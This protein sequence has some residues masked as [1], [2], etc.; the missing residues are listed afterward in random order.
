M[1]MEQQTAAAQQK[2]MGSKVHKIAA[3]LRGLLVHMGGQDP[4]ADAD[5]DADAEDNSKEDD[6]SSDVG[7]F[8][9]AAHVK[10][11]REFGLPTGDVDAIEAALE[12]AEVRQYLTKAL[13]Q[14]KPPLADAPR[15]Y[16]DML[17]T[18][19]LMDRATWPP[20]G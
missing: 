15:F 13:K 3:A 20:K 7:E 6:D 4:D 14:R 5:A 18:P 10:K 17:A 8:N 9:K 1:H 2:K 12:R 16:M 19:D 11:L